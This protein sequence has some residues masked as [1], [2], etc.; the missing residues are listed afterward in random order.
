[1]KKCL[2]KTRTASGAHHCL[3]DATRCFEAKKKRLTPI[4]CDN[5]CDNNMRIIC[6][7]LS[8]MQESTHADLISQAAS[9]MDGDF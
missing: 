1:M 7:S 5:A 4:V 8:C 3:K 6:L 2:A 9:N